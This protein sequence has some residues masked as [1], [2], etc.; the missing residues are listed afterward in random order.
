MAFCCQ[1][2]RGSLE[3]GLRAVLLCSSTG[4]GGLVLSWS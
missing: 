3:P 1:V 4:L 2:C